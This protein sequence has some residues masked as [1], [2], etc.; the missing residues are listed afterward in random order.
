MSLKVKINIKGQDY[1]GQKF[2]NP[3]YSQASENVVKRQGVKVNATVVKVKVMRKVPFSTLY[4]KK[5]CSWS[6]S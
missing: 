6:R 1:Q 5:S 2:K 4:K 3:N